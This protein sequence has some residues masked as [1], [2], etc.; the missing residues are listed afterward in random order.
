MIDGSPRGFPTPTRKI[1]LYS[2]RL[3]LSG[4]PP[5]PP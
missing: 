3:L 5:V 4:Y 1:E 2:E